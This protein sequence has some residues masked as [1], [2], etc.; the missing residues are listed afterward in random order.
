MI[1]F[2]GPLHILQ[3]NK[4]TCLRACVCICRFDV[5]YVSVYDLSFILAVEVDMV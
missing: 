1:H 5:G 2:K 4:V 3:E